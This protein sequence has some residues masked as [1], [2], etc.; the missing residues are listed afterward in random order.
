ANHLHLP[1]GTDVL[2]TNRS[3]LAIQD[4]EVIAHR[5]GNQ[6]LSGCERVAGRALADVLFSDSAFDVSDK[7]G[8]HQCD[9]HIGGGHDF[10][11]ASR[12]DIL[13]LDLESV[14]N[15]EI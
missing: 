8:P 6:S 10:S 9:G 13:L 7:V 14:R 2:V 1:R 5:S 11:V 15:D 3:L 12:A 4:H